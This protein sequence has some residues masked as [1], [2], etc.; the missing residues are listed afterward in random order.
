MLVELLRRE[1]NSG[2][3]PDEDLD[4]FMKVSYT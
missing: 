4:V 2:I 1:K 3:K